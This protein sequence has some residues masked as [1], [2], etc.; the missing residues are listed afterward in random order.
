[1]T[2]TSRPELAAGLLPDKWQSA[3]RRLLEPV[4]IAWLAA[5]RI[6]FGAALCVSMLRFLAYGWVSR[7]FV[8]PRFHFKYWGFA[9]VEPLSAEGMHVLFVALALLALSIAVGFL[10][11]L[12]A[13]AF[14][15]GLLY[16]QLIDVSTYLNHYYL[17]AL[18]AVLLAVSPAQR[19]WSLDAWLR[20][21][22]G[23]AKAGK[24]QG[25]AASQITPPEAAR[26]WL[27]LFRVQ[28]G[29][30]YFF[31]GVAKAQPDWLFHAQPLRIWLGANTHLPL[32]GPL[33]T[34]SATP[35][36]LSW[37]GFLFDSTIV[38][39]LLFRRTR[40][41]AYGLVIIFHALTR[42]LFPIGMFPVIMV[43]AAL[44]FFD[45]DWPRAL[46]GRLG[47]WFG[48]PSPSLL[49][50]FPR[51]ARE[52]APALDGPGVVPLLGLGLALAYCCLQLALPLRHL[53]YGG[54]VL[55]HEQGMRFSWRVMVRA[56]GGNTSFLVRQSS[57][58]HVWQ[59]SPRAY[60]TGLQE[61]E[62]SSQPDL[63]LQLA[64]HIHDDFVRR[65][66]G[67][68]EVRVDSRVALNGRRSARL[69][70][71]MIDLVAVR[72]GLG[73]ADWVLPAPTQ[74]PAQTRPVL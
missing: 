12:S 19:A 2:P 44:V 7:L 63:I 73:R 22:I 9:W 65:G 72:D 16:V 47:R 6:V 4:D 53:A 39:F 62:M 55:W 32:I 74:A 8:E 56:K 30:V 27:Y 59:V 60:L 46:L 43:L 25:V 52:G 36:V 38:G 33:F 40:P 42:V 58:G 51:S 26:V 70:D 5:F 68:V 28:V 14:A 71:P 3:A 21:R 57:T 13:I 29:I 54:N 34:W 31:A 50:S 49:E 41:W 15:L 24:P 35:L 10:F 48:R 66:L 20:R 18:L 37:C 1:V 45:P 17:A 67:P 64:H 69:V 61:S 11:R 23:G